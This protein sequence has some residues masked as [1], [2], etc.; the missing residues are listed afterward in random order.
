MSTTNPSIQNPV[1]APEPVA[2]ST[3]VR[4][5]VHD[6]FGSADVLRLGTVARPTVG[7]GQVLVQV[8]AAGLDR[9]TWH[10]VAGMPYAIRLAGFGVRRPRHP[11]PG[12][13]LAGVVVEVGAEV[14][15]FRPGDEV[16]G[17]A[18]GSF[19]ELAVF[20][21]DKLAHKPAS[22][23]FELAA[24]SPISCGTALQGV[25]DVGRV[26]AGQS[27]LITG[28]SGGV[29]SFAVQ[30]AKAMGAEVTG[31]CSGA[32]A[33][34]VRSI[35]ADHVVD[36]TRED[37]LAVT[38]RYDLIFDLAGNAPLS[39]LRRAVAPNGTVVIAGGEGGGR[40]LGGTDRQFR[41]VLLSLFVKPRF[42]TFI[43]REHYEVFD[44][45]TPLFDDGLV[46]P[47]IDR[48]HPLAEAADALR[49]L[50]R[51]EVCGKDVITI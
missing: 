16:Y 31:V 50:D 13:E 9:G 29:G 46:R 51:G 33:D 27:V 28:A 48:V 12:S 11:I 18:R 19:T 37:A 35:G 20:L 39:K 44:R 14:T 34:V 10:L 6:R 25:V 38:H 43:N 8:K 32:K 40:F 15:R 36:Y 17:T 41:G 22:L 49:R 24:A 2:S 26:A 23:T 7:K 42:A 47:L 45:L 5:I 1:S 4:A 30:I 21:E 3:A